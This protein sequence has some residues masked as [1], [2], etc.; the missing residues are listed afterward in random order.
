MEQYI[1]II[2]TI[3]KKETAERIAKVLVEKRLASCVQITGPI[4]STYW[5]KGKIETQKEW[6]CI[7]K[8]KKDLYKKIE[9]T[10]KQIHPYE[11]PEILAIPITRGSKD[12]LMWLG[13]ELGSS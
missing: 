9:K 3:D 8:S 4:K 11:V 2:T 5:W 7:I 12:Y 6:L 10:I 1:Q 13:N